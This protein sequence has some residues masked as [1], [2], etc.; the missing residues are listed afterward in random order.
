M[1]GIRFNWCVEW[2]DGI[3]WRVVS[4]ACAARKEADCITAGPA[5]RTHGT[6]RRHTGAKR[7]A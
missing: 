1:C 2:I 4:L 6:S 3:D 5:P 7:L